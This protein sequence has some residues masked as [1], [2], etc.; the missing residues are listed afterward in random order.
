MSYIPMIDTLVFSMDIK[1]YD[2]VTLD[3]RNLLSERKKRAKLIQSENLNEIVTVQF[4]DMVFEVL[5]NGKKGYAYILHND[6]YEIDFAQYRSKN[7]SFFPVFIK[8]KSQCLWSLSPIYA[9]EYVSRWITEYVGEIINNL[10]SRIDLCCHTDELSLSLDDVDKFKGKYYMETMYKFRRKLNAMTFGSS[11]TEKVYCR[12]YDKVL[13]VQQKKNK[14]W[15]YYI[16]DKYGLDKD[17]VWNVEFQICREYLKENSIDTVEQAFDRLR[18]IWEYCTYDWIVKIELDDNNITRCSINEKWKQLQNAFQDFKSLPLVS[19]EKQLQ[20]DA[21]A[22]IPSLYG[23]FTSFAAKKG[24]T[25]L[26][27]A[28]GIMEICGKI[29]LR[30]KDTDFRE[31]VNTKMALLDKE[32]IDGIPLSESAIMVGNRTVFEAYAEE[33]EAL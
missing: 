5:A 27:F 3:F 13:E 28:L 7:K 29:Y 22:M 21:N 16:W 26:K 20:E 11:A 23:T 14:T 19:R 6:L 9:Y 12:I 8:V 2:E 4:G 15:F 25:D 33:Q 1:D 31:L 32:G 17:K 10:I 24:I 30:S 18:T